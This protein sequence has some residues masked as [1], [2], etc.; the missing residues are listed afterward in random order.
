MVLSRLL[1]ARQSQQQPCYICMIRLHNSRH[2]S[3]A[4]LTVFMPGHVQ[5]TYIKYIYSLYWSMVTCEPPIP[6]AC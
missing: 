4:M 2:S 6:A 3:C 5:P 1:L